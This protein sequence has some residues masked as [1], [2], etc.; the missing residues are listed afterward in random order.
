MPLA[1]K[2]AGGSNCSLNFPSSSKKEKKKQ[3]KEER[4]RLKQVEKKKRRLEKALATASAIR[5]QLEK[6]KQKR[7]EEEQ[8][9]DEEGAALAEAVALQVLIDEDVDAAEENRNW[10]PNDKFWGKVNTSS[11]DFEEGNVGILGLT[12]FV[13]ANNRPDQH[14]ELQK[15]INY[16]H[17]AVAGLQ[18]SSLHSDFFYGW[19]VSV[20]RACMNVGR[21]MLEKYQRVGEQ[22]VVP[23]WEIFTCAEDK[24]KL[25]NQRA[26]AAEMAAGI[27]AAQAVAALRI[28][29]EARAEAEAAKKVVEAAMNKVVDRNDSSK[30]F[31]LAFQ[32]RGAEM[33]TTQLP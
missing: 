5:M 32:V 12:S 25:S 10:L 30:P 15:H 17:P 9:L 3:S 31:E 24:L 23:D 29:E 20:N 18:R 21:N 11:I 28:A 14:F 22:G 8:R 13:N 33:K 16:I 7:K 6:K 27:A 2:I 26:E 4:N 19:E 1:E